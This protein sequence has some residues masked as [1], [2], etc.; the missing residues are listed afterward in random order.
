MVQY[1]GTLGVADHELYILWRMWTLK[2]YVK[3]GSCATHARQYVKVE[4]ILEFISHQLV[5]SII[6]PG[7]LIDFKGKQR[8][9]SVANMFSGNVETQRR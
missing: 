9:Y 2:F 1:T 8:S 3:S 5:T 6:F 4:G 7:P